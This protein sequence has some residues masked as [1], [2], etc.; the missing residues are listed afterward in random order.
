MFSFMN[1][2]SI[3]FLMLS[4]CLVAACAPIPEKYSDLETRVVTAVDSQ[5]ILIQ[6]DYGT[7]TVLGAEDD[8]VE[9]SGQ[10]MFADEL[11]YLIDSTENQILIKVFAH[12]ES[13]S[14]VPLHVVVRLPQN[15]QVDVETKNASVAVQDYQGDVEVA[16]TSGDITLEQITG[17]M[18]LRSNRGNIT[19]R[20]SSGIVSVVGNYGV[21][22][23][24]N[25]HGDV[26]ISTIMGNIVLSGLIRGD[27][28]IRLE[29]DHGP[30]SVN[31]SADSALGIQ[32]RSTSGDVTCVL[33][34]I[35]STMRTCDGM[36]NSGGGSLSIR[37]VSG[38]VILQLLP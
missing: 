25:V 10:V 17:G 30:V 29:T 36:M 22:N 12:R 16:S 24:Q 20:E 15:M 8:L 14:K 26:S 4:V 2:F 31:L 28:T 23:T 21:L 18:T 34:G 33:P 5:L 6:V 3:L 1:R 9:I 35:S 11:E 38:A 7:V 27:D 37:T 32:V 13:S 19:V